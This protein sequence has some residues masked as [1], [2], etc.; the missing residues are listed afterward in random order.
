M[1]QEVLSV[2]WGFQHLLS[3]EARIISFTRE[4]E[5][6]QLIKACKGYVCQ[7]S[8]QGDSISYVH[9]TLSWTEHCYMPRTWNGHRG[10][11]I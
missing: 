1:R 10:G 2:T 6:E 11:K 8:S 3:C 5:I 9:V 7:N 4:Q